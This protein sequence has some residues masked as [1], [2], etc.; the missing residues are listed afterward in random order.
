VLSACDTV[1]RKPSDDA[2]IIALVSDLVS[3]TEVFEIDFCV[4]F[5]PTDRIT[6]LSFRCWVYGTWVK[7]PR[8]IGHNFC[9]TY[10]LDYAP[11]SSSRALASFISAAWKP[12]V[13]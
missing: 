5:L 3:V 8:S 10:R 12:L 13:N 6:A 2:E 4:V 7:F 11:R 1:E 9:R